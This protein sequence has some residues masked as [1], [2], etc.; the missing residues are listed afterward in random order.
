MVYGLKRSERPE[1][2]HTTVAGVNEGNVRLFF[3]VYTTRENFFA[4]QRTAFYKRTVIV[5]WKPASLIL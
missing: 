2:D 4:D 5:F 3:V 1:K